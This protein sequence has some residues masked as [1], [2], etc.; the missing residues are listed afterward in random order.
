MNEF[1]KFCV[2]NVMP[3]DVP[4]ATMAWDKAIELCV[5]DLQSFLDEDVDYDEFDLKDCLKYMKKLNSEG[6]RDI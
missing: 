3:Q 4:I 6:K 2:E 1:N 5:K